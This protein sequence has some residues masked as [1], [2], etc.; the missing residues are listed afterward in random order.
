MVRP[1][2]IIAMALACLAFGTSEAA[3]T[4]PTP[5]KAPCDSAATIRPVI[6]TPYD[7]ARAET[8]LPAM[9]TPISATSTVFRETLEPIAVSSGAPTTTPRA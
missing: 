1:V 9:K 4:D 8:R 6:S 2:N 7:E 5:K 3:T